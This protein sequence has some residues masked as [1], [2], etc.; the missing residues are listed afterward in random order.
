MHQ[1]IAPQTIC[2]GGAFYMVSTSIT[3]GVEAYYQWYNDNGPA[4]P[5]TNSIANEQRAN[6]RSFPTV[7]GV[8]KY[9]IVATS[10][11][12]ASCNASQSVTLTVNPPPTITSTTGTNPRCAPAYGGTISVVGAGGNTLLYSKDNGSTWVDLTGL[13]AQDEITRNALLYT[14]VKDIA[15][16]KITLEEG[17]GLGPG[18]EYMGEIRNQTSPP[19]FEGLAAGTYSIR[20]KNENGCISDPASVALTNPN[21][22][23]HCTSNHLLWRCFLHGQY[24]YHQRGRSLLP[25]V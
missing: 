16:V 8:Y 24:Q 25:M 11:A 23:T 9:K 4:N 20:V 12:D 17:F 2:Y 22:P 14:T 7:P 10:A 13:N 3:N 18:G 21:A 19:V 5:N 1:P 6:L 15:R